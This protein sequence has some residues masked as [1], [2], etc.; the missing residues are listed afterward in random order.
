[1]TRTSMMVGDISIVY[2]DAS[3]VLSISDRYIELC[4]E[5]MTTNPGTIIHIRDGVVYFKHPIDPL[6]ITDTGYLHQCLDKIVDI[7]HRIVSV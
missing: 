3:D 1:M 7:A 2:T 5:I 4:R 6:H